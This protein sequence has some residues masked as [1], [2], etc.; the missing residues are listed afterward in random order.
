MNKSEAEAIAAR[1]D[2]RAERESW[3][4]RQAQLKEEERAR[5]REEF[6]RSIP[7][8]IFT[9]MR[10][11]TPVITSRTRKSSNAG[12]RS[13][14]QS[15]RVSSYQ[16]LGLS[17]TNPS[18]LDRPVSR[19]SSPMVVA[20]SP[21]TAP[22]RSFPLNRT[23]SMSTV[24]N[25]SLNNGIPETPSIDYDAP[26]PG[27]DDDFFNGVHTPATPPERTIND[28]VSASTAAAGPSVQLVE[29]MSAAVRRLESEKAAHRDELARF[30]QQRDEAREQ[31]VE[32]MRDNEGKKAVDDRLQVLEKESGE[33]KKRYET[34]LEM[35]G[36]KSEKV[37]ELKADIVDLKTMMREMVEERVR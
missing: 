32:L 18:P 26:H 8:N 30:A 7:T 5:M 14:P 23:D 17:N 21:E 28:V 10:T 1:N 3:E 4:S 19:R 36:E 34:T 9:Q 13:S 6:M 20:D 35:L 24:P 12:D 29:R 2:L 22:S 15:R 25:I 31:V 11:D 33:L 16:G 27:G 37:E